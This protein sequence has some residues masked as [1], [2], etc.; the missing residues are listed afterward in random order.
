MVVAKEPQVSS[1]EFDYTWEVVLV[2]GEQFPLTAAEDAKAP[3]D[4]K[5]AKD[6]ADTKDAEGLT[7]F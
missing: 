2:N 7:L 3:A 4:T 6:M 1:I 5:D